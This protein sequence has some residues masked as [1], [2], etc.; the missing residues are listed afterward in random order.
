[1]TE[2]TCQIQLVNQ[3]KFVHWNEVHIDKLSN[4]CN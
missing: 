3:I 1:M 2:E 4:M